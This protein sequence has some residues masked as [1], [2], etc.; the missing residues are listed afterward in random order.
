[1]LE[2]VS[3]HP[4]RTSARDFPHHEGC[5]RRGPAG[6]AV[7]KGTCTRMADPTRFN[8][9]DRDFKLPVRWDECRVRCAGRSQPE[10]GTAH[11]LPPPPPRMGRYPWPRPFAATASIQV[12]GCSGRRQR[13][14]TCDKQCYTRRPFRSCSGSVYRQV[15]PGAWRHAPGSAHPAPPRRC[16]FPARAAESHYGLILAR[17]PY[18]GIR[19]SC[20]QRGRRGYVPP[21]HTRDPR[22]LAQIPPADTPAESLDGRAMVRGVDPH[23]SATAGRPVQSHGRTR[24][25]R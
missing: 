3:R 17:T 6:L 8:R 22:G 25:V 14:A 18:C 24:A 15:S 16:F 7:R 21:L 13:R 23:A 1:M 19:A 5:C 4:R 11:P 9:R 12:W 10:D 2:P 20:P